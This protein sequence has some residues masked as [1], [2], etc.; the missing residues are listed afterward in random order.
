MH[1]KTQTEELTHG[2]SNDFVLLR[3]HFEQRKVGKAIH[4]KENHTVLKPKRKDKGK[5][6]NGIQLRN[7]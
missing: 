5:G 3:K 7:A 1:S 6:V 2:K 4:K